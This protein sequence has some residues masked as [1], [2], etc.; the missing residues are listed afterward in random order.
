VIPGKTTSEVTHNSDFD[1]FAFDLTIS[2]LMSRPRLH[3]WLYGTPDNNNASNHVL[4]GAEV[5]RRLPWDLYL[6]TPFH[7]TTSLVPPPL[8]YLH[9]IVSG[10]LTRITDILV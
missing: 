8:C 7:H 4:T 2:W 5:G 9:G 1:R 10:R 6:S 3:S